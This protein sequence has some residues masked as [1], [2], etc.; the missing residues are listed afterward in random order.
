MSDFWQSPEASAAETVSPAALALP[1]FEQ[2]FVP[3]TDKFAG[4]EGAAEAAD[5]A[6]ATIDI[7]QLQ[8]DA[9]AEGFNEGRRTV[10]MEVATE[11]DAIARLAESLEQYRPEPPEALAELLAE[12]VDRLVRQIVGEAVIDTAMLESRVAAVAGIITEAAAPVRMRL[13]P[14]DAERIATANMEIEVVADEALLPGS[15]FVETGAGWIEDGPEVGIEKLR[16]ALER[17]SVPQ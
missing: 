11:R 10:E 6:P 12:T 9:F 2:R 13:H 7:T 4:G 3:W 5:N 14:E 16:Q 1:M 15:V 8:A 17:M